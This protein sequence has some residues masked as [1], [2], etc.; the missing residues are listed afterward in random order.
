MDKAWQWCCANWELVTAALW[1]ASLVLQR[2]TKSFDN[3]SGWRRAVLV[4]TEFATCIR[5]KGAPD[6]KLGPLKWFWQHVPSQIEV[7]K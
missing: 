7:K 5:S 2:L 1:L 3:S 4:F 6:G